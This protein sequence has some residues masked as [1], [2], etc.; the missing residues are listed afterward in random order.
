MGSLRKMRLTITNFKMNSNYLSFQSFD[1]DRTPVSVP[2]P[3]WT[4]F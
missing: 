4:T 3:V 1:C 2:W